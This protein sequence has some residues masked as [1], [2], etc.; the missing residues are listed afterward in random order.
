MQNDLLILAKNVA[1]DFLQLKE[2][3]INADHV[4]DEYPEALF[5][6]VGVDLIHRDPTLCCWINTV[7]RIMSTVNHAYDSDYDER[8]CEGGGC[9]MPLPGELSDEDL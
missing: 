8:G 3:Q 5:K 7:C 1:V 9:G 2:I 6:S 4:C